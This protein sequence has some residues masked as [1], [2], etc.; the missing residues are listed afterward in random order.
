MIRASLCANNVKTRFDKISSYR[1]RSIQMKEK[2]IAPR[3]D[4]VTSSR[5]KI[6]FRYTVFNI[7]TS[8]PNE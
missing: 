6:C 5:I 8:L 2:T 4:N 7:D 1:S 3:E